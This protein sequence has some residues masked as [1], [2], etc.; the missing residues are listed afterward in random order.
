MR[1]LYVPAIFAALLVSLPASAATP[2]TPVPLAL[3]LPFV[4]LLA[5]IALGPLVALHF[6]HHHYGK[7]AA[8]W[9]VLAAAGLVLVAGPA[10]TAAMLFHTLAL[11]Y[12]PFILMLLALFTC[13]GGLVVRGDLVGRPRTNVAILAL[14]TLLAS[15]VGTTGAAMILI[16]PLLRANAHRRKNAHVVVFFIFLVG[17]VGGALS[18]LGD[19]PL[20]LGFLRGV[21]FFWPL[22]TLWPETLGLAIVLLALFAVLDTWLARRDKPEALG[23]IHSAGHLRLGGAI[24]LPLIL[25]AVGAIVASGVW[26]PG[27]AVEILGT[28]LET[29]NLVRES[30]LLLVALASIFLTP[31]DARADNAFDWE[32]IAEVAKIFAA[33][34]VCLVPVMSMLQAGSH[35]PFAPLTALV[36]HADGRPIDWAYFWM[37]GLISSVLDNAPTYL[38]FFELAGGDAHAL[39]GPLASTLTAISLGAVFMGAGTYIGNAPNFMVYAIARRAGVRMPG[40]FGYMAWSAGILLPLFVV[41]TLL[42]FRS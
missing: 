16:R 29:Q 20:F 13:A 18:P 27:V 17:N 24:N 10:A 31:D 40:F 23:D 3:G 36:Q 26:R 41:L 11:E 7:V 42:V 9:G 8:L 15:L 14:G 38:V 21:D 19:P 28:P 33:L 2:G 39:M 34:F 12:V 32:P 22:R 25:V 30:V 4:G 5:S 1:S 35:G 6:W 37:T